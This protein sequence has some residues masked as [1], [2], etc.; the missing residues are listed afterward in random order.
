M[1]NDSIAGS[2]RVRSEV[3]MGAGPH[4]LVVPVRARGMLA[5]DEPPPRR[6]HSIETGVKSWNQLCTETKPFTFS[7][8]ARGF[9]SWTIQSQG[10][11]S[12]RI[13]FSRGRVDFVTD[14]SVAF[15]ISVSRASNSSFFQCPQFEPGGV[16]LPDQNQRAIRSEAHTSDMT[17]LLGISYAVF[18]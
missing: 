18:C 14:G 11:S 10:A 6:R 7:D 9:R 2:R 13:S 15:W 4:V 5:G 16:T 1:A 3:P 12:T 17:S 8:I